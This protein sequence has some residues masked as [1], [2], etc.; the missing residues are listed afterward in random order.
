MVIIIVTIVVVVV[1]VVV[2]VAFK[3][4]IYSYIFETNHVSRVYSVTAV[5]YL[6]F[7]I[8]VMLFCTVTYFVLLHTYFL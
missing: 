6:Q 3:Q 8:C 2:I 4:S 5:L 7:V 1:V